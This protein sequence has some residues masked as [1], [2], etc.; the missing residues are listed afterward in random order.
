LRD[1][2]L[3]AVSAYDKEKFLYLS[4]L[5]AAYGILPEAVKVLL[6]TE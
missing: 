5:Q 6:L 1:G 2:I 3:T 4:G